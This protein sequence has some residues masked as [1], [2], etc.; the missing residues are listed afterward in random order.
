MKKYALGALVAVV[1][2]SGSIQA[3][4]ANQEP[5]S[6]QEHAEYS[7]SKIENAKEA[8]AISHKEA[9]ELEH[10]VNKIDKK[11]SWL[12]EHDKLDRKQYNK[13]TADLHKENKKVNKAEHKNHMN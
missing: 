7:K 11:A 1:A 2:I 5:R 3:F 10:N 13:L 9:H 12:K 6:V 8:G 4:A